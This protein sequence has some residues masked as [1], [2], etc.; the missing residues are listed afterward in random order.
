MA[1]GQTYRYRYGYWRE[2]ESCCRYWTNRGCLHPGTFPLC[3]LRRAS[4]DLVFFQGYG[5]FTME[6]LKV[7]SQGVVLTRGPGTY[8]IPSANDIPRQF[9]VKLL[10]GSSNKR[11]IFSS[12]VQS[13]FLYALFRASSFSGSGR[14]PAVSRVIRLLRH[15]RRDQI[16]T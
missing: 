8:K 10:K 1:S 3:A 2:H 13:S 6:E 9:N 5:L 15:Q 14:T 12:K 16:G 7:S 11:A 4:M